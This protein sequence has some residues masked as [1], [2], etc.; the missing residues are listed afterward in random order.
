LADCSSNRTLIQLS[1]EFDENVIACSKCPR[2]RAYCREVAAVKRRAYLADDY[3]G[4]PVPSFGPLN[5]QLLILGL[6][7][8]AH[9]ANRTGRVFTGDSSGNL[10]FRVL[11]ATG[12]ATQPVSTSANDG[13]ELIDARITCAAHCAPPQNR[14]LPAEVRNC[15]TWL[16]RELALMPNLKAVVALGR[17]AFDDYLAIR[18]VRAAFGHCAIHKEDRSG[19]PVLIASYHPSQQNTSTGKLTEPMFRAV[20]EAARDV[21]TRDKN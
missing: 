8:G 18:Q 21:V 15:R 4:R 19:A 5:A 1:A 6:A 16:E 13:L 10:L 9:G 3:W 11:H 2:L 14:P 17:L 12:F 7:P 20:F